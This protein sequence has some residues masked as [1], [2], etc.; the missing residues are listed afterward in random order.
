MQKLKCLD[1]ISQECNDF[2]KTTCNFETEVSRIHERIIN[3]LISVFHANDD[4]IV[5]QEAIK[6]GAEELQK[7]TNMLLQ[8][9]QSAKVALEKTGM[10]NATKMEQELLQLTD[11]EKLNMEFI[12]DKIDYSQKVLDNLLEK[13]EIVIK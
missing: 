7:S 12:A 11:I 6:Q 3:L 13:D 10:V 9:L 8:K 5:P 1:C 4:A 2:A